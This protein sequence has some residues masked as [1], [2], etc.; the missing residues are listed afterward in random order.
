[1]LLDVIFELCGLCYF[2]NGPKRC[3]SSINCLLLGNNLVL[4]V[5]RYWVNWAKGSE[6][7]GIELWALG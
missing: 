5:G 2:P 6:T 7:K 4:K 1:M 3:G